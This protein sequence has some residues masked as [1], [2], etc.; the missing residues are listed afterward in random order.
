MV[1]LAP[2]T[3][4]EEA[5]PDEVLA[6]LRAGSGSRPRFDPGLA[7]GL[8][9]WLEDAA[10]LVVRARGEDAPP[11]H[12]GPRLLVGPSGGAVGG[13]GAGSDG[14]TRP[15]VIACLVHAVFRQLVVSG[16]V[17]DPLDDALHALAVDPWQQD[18]VEAVRRLAAVD[19]RALAEEVAAHVTRLRAMMPVLQP[20]WLPRTGDRVSVALAGGRVVL[21]G[22]FDLLVGAPAEGAAA[23]LCVVGLTTTGPWA[24]ARLKLHLLALLETIRSG[25]PPFRLALLHSGEGRFGAEDVTEADIGDVVSQVAGRLAEMA[26][27]AD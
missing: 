7:G 24:R 1:L 2:H 15:V 5:R 20:S 22:T 27:A 25:V 14:L 26:D 18:A 6:Q 12:V 10:S 13:V 11:L 16:A 19:R 4:D 3:T 17:D 9:A 21:H 8:R 23:S